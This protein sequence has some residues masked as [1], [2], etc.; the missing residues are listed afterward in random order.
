MATSVVGDAAAEPYCSAAEHLHDELMRLDLLVRGQVVRARH[1]SGD[2]PYRGL[3]IGEPEV[4]ALLARRIGAPPW[5]AS[6]V[7]PSLAE[8]HALAE[9]MAAQIERRSARANV[10]LPLVE[11]ARRFDLDRFDLDVVMIAL[12]PELDL[13]YERLYAYLH[14]DVTRKRP[15]VDL[16]LSLLCRSFDERLAARERFGVSGT[17]VRHGVVQIGADATAPLLA[18]ALKLDDRIVDWLHGSD[19]L[20]LPLGRHARRIKPVHAIADLVCAPDVVE[21][22][23]HL[24][25]APELPWLY[26]HGPAGGGKRTV[27][28][29]LAHARART[30]LVLD[31]DLLEGASDEVCESAIRAA[32]RE[33]V[34]GDDCLLIEHAER[35]LEGE[36]RASRDALVA[37][38]AM[39]PAIILTGRNAW[40]PTDTERSRTF[41]PL[42]IAAPSSAAQ[43][44]LWRRALA[45]EAVEENV[46][47]EALAGRMR[48]TG[49]QLHDAVAAALG[50]ATARGARAISMADLVEGCRRQAGRRLGS[51]ARAVQGRPRWDDLVLPIDRVDRLRELCDHVRHRAVVLE[52]W[53][54]DRRLAN[55]KAASAMFVGAPGTGKTLAA[56]IIASELGLE[57][58]QIDLASVVSKWIGETEKNLAR[59]FDEAER[60]H[61]VLFFDEADA[62]FAKRTELRDAHD[63]YANL[64]TSYLLQRIEAYEGIV[65]LASNFRRNLDEAFVRRLRFIIEFPL[66]DE[67]ERLRIWKGIWP[68]QTPRTPDVD[69]EVMARRFDVAGAYIRNIAVAAAFLAAAE[70][71]PISQQHLLRAARREYQKLGKMVDEQL[72]AG[73]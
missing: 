30:L 20:A 37:A 2:D 63:R 40:E 61:G 62:L 50:I 15:S 8:A 25:R 21:S 60:G 64:E 73:A 52:Q 16:A 57:L 72:F 67:H 3:A 28:E 36:R 48:M 42:A 23:R 14:D 54:F 29:A 55:G 51:S 43:A 5:D 46:D 71:A 44:E 19:Q 70:S 31:A 17:L 6:G 35:W 33:A 39:L 1:A 32:A 56:S 47:V 49:G 24:A 10:R 7:G 45:S 13:R 69:L 68:S 65:I 66:P 4:D 27:A 22:V 9:R 11:L 38:A 58:F 18:R 53:G 41:V 26:L 34:L 59:I 12:A